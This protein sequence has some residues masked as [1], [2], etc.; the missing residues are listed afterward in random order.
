MHLQSRKTTKTSDSTIGFQATIYTWDLP[1]MKLECYS[2]HCHVKFKFN[3]SCN[4]N[5]YV[6]CVESVL[7]T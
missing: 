6:P 2:L 1:N 5:V 3:V 7:N 4:L